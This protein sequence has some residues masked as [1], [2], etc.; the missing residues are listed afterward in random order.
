MTSRTKNWAV[1][2]TKQAKKNRSRGPLRKLLLEQLEDRRL[3]A[4]YLWSDAAGTLS[5]TLGTGEDLTISESG[6]V[7]SFAIDSG[8]FA[9]GVGSDTATGEATGTI[10][11]DFS[12]PNNISTSVSVDNAGAGAD[13]NNVTFAGG[14]LT[15]G[16]LTVNANA[17]PASAVDF[18]GAMTLAGNVSLTANGAGITDST[19]SVVV[20]GTTTLTATGQDIVLDAAGNDFVGDVSIWDANNVTLA[21]SNGISLD[22]LNVGGNLNVT[23]GGDITDSAVAYVYVV[24][25]ASF[26]AGSGSNI[27]LD[28]LDVQSAI[29]VTTSGDA[30]IS[31]WAPAA[32]AASSVGGNLAVES[33]TGDVDV[34]GKLTVGGAVNLN[35][36]GAIHVNADVDPTMVTMMAAGDIVV[37]AAV[38]ATDG[39]VVLAGTV[40]G[41]GGVS[42]T[43]NGSLTTTATPSGITISTGTVSGDISL[44]GPVEVATGGS[45]A[46]TSSAG[47]VT[48]DAKITGSGAYS[49]VYLTAFTNLTINAP[50][51][52]PATVMLTSG[53]DV[54][55]NAA[56]Q[57]TDGITVT[58]GTDGT[59]GINVTATGSLETTVAGFSQS[60]VSISTGGTS[61]DV[62]LTGNITTADGSVY[63]TSV[64]G[65]ITMA[66]GSVIDAGSGFIMLTATGD[67]SLG[68]GDIT[69]GLLTTTYTDSY[70]GDT[71]IMVNAMGTVIDADG[72]AGLDLVSPNGGLFVVATNGVG[73]L[74]DSIEFRASTLYVFN[75]GSGDIAMWTDRSVTVLSAFQTASTGSIYLTASDPVASPTITVTSSGVLISSGPGDVK[76]VAEG[77]T[78]SILLNALVATDTG[79]LLLWADHDIIGGTDVYLQVGDLG[80]IEV[81][82]NKD[83]SNNPG[84]D[85]DG[86]IQFSA[87]D[88]T[89]KISILAGNDNKVSFWLGDCDG[90]IDGSISAANEVS[91]R[92]RGMLRLNGTQNNYVGDTHIYDGGLLINGALT[93]TGGG[94]SLGVIHVWSSLSSADPGAGAGLLGGSGLIQDDDVA[95]TA[96]VRDVFVHEGGTLDPGDITFTCEPLPGTLEIW[97]DVVFEA[98]STYRL[99]LDGLFPGDGAGFH[100]QLVVYGAVS[101]AGDSVGA[102]GANLVGEITYDA[103]VGSRWEIVENDFVDSDLITTRFDG[104]PELGFAV[105]SGRLVNVSYMDD[106]QGAFDNDVV[107][108]APGRFDFNGFHEV[109]QSSL[110]YDMWEGV[111][112]F[113]TYPENMAG[114]VGT[115]PWYFERLSVTNPDWDALRYDG[116][117]TN[118]MGDP[119]NFRVDVIAGQTYEVMILAGDASW[120][121][122]DQGYTVEGTPGG[123]S[124]STRPGGI[125]TWGAGAPDGTGVQV[126]WG[127]GTANPTA[128]YYRWIHLT[129]DVAGQYGDTGNITLTMEGLA[130]LLGRTGTASILAMDIRPADAVGEMTLERIEPA[131]TSPFSALPAD[132]TTLDEYKGT[133]APPNAVLTVTVSAGTPVQ[134]ATVTPDLVAAVSPN[135]DLATFGAQIQADAN[136]DFVFYV[137]RPATLTVNAETEDWTILVEECVGLSRGS[138]IQPYK[139][140]DAEESA[141]LRFDF[142]ATTSPV[143]KYGASMEKEFQPV[144]PQTIYNATRGYGWAN[145]VAA[146]DRRDNYTTVGYVANPDP[147]STPPPAGT[148][149]TASP[150]RT[151]FNSGRNAT[152]RVDLPDGDYNVR[153]YHSNPLY[154]GRVPY[155]TQPFDVIVEGTP[156]YAVPVIAPGTTFIKE[157]KV[158]V[159]GGTLDILF[160]SGR[161]PFMI[162]GI[163]ISKGTLPSDM[164]LVAAGNP[165]DAGGT[166]IGLAELQSVATEAA[167]LWAATGL[168]DQQASTL[169]SVQ[170]AVTDLG[171]AYLGL[172]N[173]A[174]NTVR[175]DDDAAMIGWSA[176]GERLLTTDPRSPIAGM[177]L[178][179]VV[180]HELGHLLGYA[181]SDESGDLMAPVLSSGRTAG[182]QTGKGLAQAEWGLGTSSLFVPSA[183]LLSDSSSRLD[184]AFADLGREEMPEP[185]DSDDGAWPLLASQDGDELP[186]ATVKAAQ[187]VAQANV[188]RRSRME[189]FE[190]ELDKWFA[191]LATAGV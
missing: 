155:T 161:T 91:K 78:A 64:K 144:Y 70:S 73:T 171:G 109:T 93:N 87:T 190:R 92:G 40:G 117:T 183:S 185:A 3:L 112:P 162:A 26:T 99:Q 10:S 50:I 116:Q 49:S 58:A 22:Y 45:L 35:A 36:G 115:L 98:G 69:L 135:G 62:L 158:T 57:A 71:A 46:A 152:F 146:G 176:A 85:D 137:Q 68:F 142:G 103:P 124:D 119:V 55:V 34:N 166:M 172:T 5:I 122:D 84:D 53:D 67:P 20:T 165:Q 125:D 48:V 156:S 102:G 110:P 187:E 120:N 127:G 79:D 88:P 175:I 181:H 8:T 42:V 96:A 180:M 174:T 168:T 37:N 59:G 139:E 60:G 32:V 27:V 90:F 89:T 74:A 129:V 145:R 9:A 105:F 157:V 66:D 126:P 38:Q 25:T 16:T 11:F 31:N 54:I 12:I 138:E 143:Q 108:T 150:L 113:Q 141:P 106:L 118:P 29:D 154:F 130:D 77:P 178:L 56:V 151:D 82:A 65:D 148:H 133:G 24:G 97:G 75:Q 101:F 188:P 153:L 4:S 15:T 191:E 173:A 41:A 136:G 76:L 114:W 28:A 81:W 17:G 19:G 18:T 184:G 123:D 13:T 160:G 104:I 30:T 149:D 186:V 131:G 47:A 140:P 167:A 7:R 128:G 33:L 21:D 132:G 95:P 63:V 159:S 23:A 134:Y 44:A 80:A 51:D 111:S 163:D 182:L 100:D 170:Y 6:G 164:P 121:H 39:I 43:T 147:Y 72:G 1:R 2:D 169:A 61:G 177:D 52:P 179:T 86:T 94:T 107:L 189:Q 14:T 83:N